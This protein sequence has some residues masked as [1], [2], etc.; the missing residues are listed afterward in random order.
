MRES[1][2]RPT[3]GQHAC[4]LAQRHGE[5]GTMTL[6][7]MPEDKFGRHIGG[8]CFHGVDAGHNQ[9]LPK[10]KLRSS[11]FRAHSLG[12]PSAY[13]AGYFRQRWG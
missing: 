8:R 11:S 2:P 3:G 7:S 5:P 13:V 1:L 10:F 9:D 12:E 4:D 6:A